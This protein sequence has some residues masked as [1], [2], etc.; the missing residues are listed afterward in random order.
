MKGYVDINIYTLRKI[1]ILLYDLIFFG[2]I[3]VKATNFMKHSNTWDATSRSGIQ[4]TC[5]LLLRSLLLCL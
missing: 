1:A 4:E 2:V 5:P 3:F